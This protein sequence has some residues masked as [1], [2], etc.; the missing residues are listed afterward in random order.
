MKNLPLS[1]QTF[2]KIRESGDLYVDK[3]KYIHKLT[4]IGTYYFL[5][6]PRRFGKS[7]MLSTFKSYF[8]GKKELFKGLFIDKVEQNW[9]KYP[10]IYIDYSFVDYKNGKSVFEESFLNLLKRIA[11]DYQVTVTNTAIISDYFI[12]LIRALFT[13]FGKVVILVDEYDKPLVDFLNNP[14]QFEENRK[15]LH[16]I[17]STVKGLDQYLRF[18][19]LTGVSRFSKIS[20]FSGM[21]NL[22]DISMASDYTEIVGFSQKE[23]EDNFSEYFTIAQQKMVMDENTLKTGLK[24]YYNGYSW[25]GINRLYNPFS[26]INFFNDPKFENYWF[27]SGTPTFLMNLIKEQ[28]QLPENFDNQFLSDLVGYSQNATKIP[29]LALLFQTGYLTIKKIEIDGFYTT[30]YLGYP[31]REVELSFTIFLMA[32]FVNKSEFAIQPE[33]IRLRYAL[34]NEQFDLFVDIIQSF[35][36][37]IPARLHLPKEA[38]Y[39]SLIYMLLRLVGVKM[40]LEK[41]TDKGR[42]DAIFEHQDKVYVFEFK[43]ATNK[44][45]KQVNTLANKALAQILEK[46]YYE[47]YVG[48]G[49][50]IILFGIGFLE[51]KLGKAI[52]VLGE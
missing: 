19:M 2:E 5:S 9:Q 31:N 14:I 10:I 20:V 24:N 4:S 34:Y 35:F 45:I 11:A 17:Y 23:L 52:K 8:E 43:F 13:K 37:D 6:R 48:S 18:V 39:H 41:E 40:I 29:V 15:I 32:A 36:A 21:N 38:Y 44:R 28:K 26:I 42:I 47:P 27:S 46:K 3:T 50:K 51:K 49:K 12:D 22:T 30:Y 16:A 1:I 33:A 7:L 25:D